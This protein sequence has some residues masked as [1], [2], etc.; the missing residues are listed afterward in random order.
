MENVKLKVIISDGTHEYSEYVDLKEHRAQYG[1]LIANGA[2]PRLD[3]ISFDDYHR[4]IFLA[5][6][7]LKLF[8]GTHFLYG[9][10]ESFRQ[11]NDVPDWAKENKHLNI[12]VQWETIEWETNSED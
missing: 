1:E 2:N 11:G 6:P 3:D 9:W 10:W 8:N 12:H 5:I 4:E 7:E